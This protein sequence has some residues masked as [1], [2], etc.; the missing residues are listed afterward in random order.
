MLSPLAAT[1]FAQMQHWSFHYLVSL[2]LALSN[3]TVLIIIFRL[4]SGDG[5]FSAFRYKYQNFVLINIGQHA[6]KMLDRK[7]PKNKQVARVAY[8]KYCG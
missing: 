2:A 7:R 4:K 6:S 1:Q 8:D 5:L 3:T